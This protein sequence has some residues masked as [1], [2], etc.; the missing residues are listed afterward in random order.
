[1]THKRIGEAHTA[2]G[3]RIDVRRSH[4]R[5]AITTECAGCLIVREKENYVRTGGRLQTGD[6]WKQGKDEQE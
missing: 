3:Q 6:S 5:V 2:L 4:N 1:M